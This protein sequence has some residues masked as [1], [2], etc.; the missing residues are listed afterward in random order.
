MQCQLTFCRA[1]L[2]ACLQ[3]I[4]VQIEEPFGILALEVFCDN[5]CKNI[6]QAQAAAA[7]LREAAQGHLGVSQVPLPLPLPAAAAGISSVAG[8]EFT[9]QAQ[10][11]HHMVGTAVHG[12]LGT[13]SSSSSRTATDTGSSMSSG[14][15][16][17]NSSSSSNMWHTQLGEMQHALPYSAAVQKH[18]TAVDAEGLELY[19]GSTVAAPEGEEDGFTM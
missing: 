15:I 1:L 16:S 18:L 11:A 14:S 7:P 12:M 4:G 5:I 19:V 9:A 2:C 10:E 8:H 17:A 13:A 6:K 3:E